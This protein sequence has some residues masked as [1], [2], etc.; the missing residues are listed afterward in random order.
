MQTTYRVSPQSSAFQPFERIKALHQR[1][2][3]VFKDAKDIKEIPAFYDRYIAPL[4]KLLTPNQDEKAID[5]QFAPLAEVLQSKGKVGK[6]YLK[7]LELYKL[8]FKWAHIIAMPDEKPLALVETALLNETKSSLD[9]KEAKEIVESLAGPYFENVSRGVSFYQSLENQILEFNDSV[10][11]LNKQV[12]E[13]KKSR[14]HSEI[15]PPTDEIKSHEETICDHDEFIGLL[16]EEES[17]INLN[18]DFDEQKK[19]REILLKRWSNWCKDKE[20]ELIQEDE[21]YLDELIKRSD[22]EKTFHEYSHVK[23]LKEV[24][25][26]E[27]KIQRS[28]HERYDFI[29]SSIVRF[30]A[31]VSN[32]LKENSH[33]RIMNVISA[34]KRIIQE[35]CK[36][37]FKE[38]ETHK[39]G[40]MQRIE[41]MRQTVSQRYE[42]AKKSS[43]ISN[44]NWYQCI[45]KEW[46]LYCFRK[47]KEKW[48]HVISQLNRVLTPRALDLHKAQVEE[49]M[50]KFLE[51][52]IEKLK[53][54]F[55]GTK[56][57]IE[58]DTK[59][60]NTIKNIRESVELL[61]HFYVDVE[62]LRENLINQ[63]RPYKCRK[64]TASLTRQL[65]ESLLQAVSTAVVQQRTKFIQRQL[66][67]YGERLAAIEKLPERNIQ[68]IT[69]LQQEMFAFGHEFGVTE[70]NCPS[71]ANEIWKKI[72]NYRHYYKEAKTKELRIE[73]DK[74]KEE[75]DISSPQKTESFS[76]KFRKWQEETTKIVKNE[77]Q[78]LGLS[79]PTSRWILAGP[80]RFSGELADLSAKHRQKIR[81]SKSNSRLEKKEKKKK[82]D[83]L[84]ARTSY[85]VIPNEPEYSCCIAIICIIILPIVGLFIYN[86]YYE[87]ACE[88][89]RAEAAARQ[90]AM[91]AEHDRQQPPV[92][93][94]VS[95]NPSSAPLSDISMRGRL[96]SPMTSRGKNDIGYPERSIQYKLY[97]APEQIGLVQSLSA[98]VH[99][100]KQFHRQTTS[101]T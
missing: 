15:I 29:K 44:E 19:T 58:E 43:E 99:T 98:P 20:K 49:K 27:E 1:F 82:K 4:A 73:T 72:A 97:R 3:T 22:F 52:I 90:A 17:L 12:Q 42:K 8:Y 100:V 71:S 74:K 88:K 56:K 70:A 37:F 50:K 79:P 18:K 48:A 86:C 21:D 60:E 77:C 75:L 9:D 41:G 81:Q 51:N 64:S 53:I 6:A 25:K 23:K 92:E 35:E 59:K 54:D 84:A 34:E 11:E 76:A 83:N 46:R 91:Q 24:C 85:V 101:Q 13:E 62:T 94:S 87:W 16:K 33:N 66:E 65:F 30:E 26:D 10:E 55:E 80:S 32:F 2:L 69:Q 68:K 31:S 40:I 96:G 28:T 61:K 38:I 67:N 63:L 39:E 14:G 95:D 89:A 78:L 36:S 47:Y 45:K 7:Y 93:L 57:K 5:D